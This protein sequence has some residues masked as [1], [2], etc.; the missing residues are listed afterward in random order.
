MKKIISILFILCTSVLLLITGC[1]KNHQG[2][3]ESFGNETSSILY[4]VGKN[5]LPYKDEQIFE[6]LFDRNNLIQVS[7]NISE[8]ELL[9]IQK[10]Y[11]EYSNRGSKS[12][13]YRNASMDITITTE[14]NSITYRIP[15]VGV[16]MKGNTSRTDFYSQEEGQYNL[17]HYRVKFM[18]GEFA[19]LD[20]LELKWN[21]NDDS[22]YIREG[23]AYEM[24]RDMGVL[25]PHTNLV[26]MD[27]SG[28]H[29]GVFTM[30]EPVDKN[31][32]EKNVAEK[33]WGG[34]LYKC[35]WT[36]IGAS[37]TRECSI[38][39][40]DEEHSK[41]YN[42][43]LKTNKLESNHAQMR[44]LIKVLN[45]S[46]VSRESMEEV[47]DMDNFVMFAAVSYFVGNPDDCRNNYNNYYIYFL[48]SSGKAIFIPYDLD[49][50]FGVTKDFNPCG[51]AM[52]ANSPYSTKAKGA[53][54][55]MQKNPLFVNTVQTNSYFFREYTQALK[56]AGESK[57]MTFDHFN[58][59]YCTAEAI[60]GKYTTPEK[61][62]W[63][64]EHHNFHFDVNQSEGLNTNYG[65]ASF[66]EYIDAKMA[67]YDSFVE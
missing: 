6:Q 55:E 23:Y 40:E 42:Y 17:I 35:G 13:I 12:P 61:T 54:N 63:N 19:S 16:R 60:Y 50:V 43:D 20:H 36:H 1:D 4:T 7:L 32:I 11:E 33:D 45:T 28:L 57:W 51:E 52:T 22:T 65:N 39:V 10:D 64:G 56:T 38:G 9:N 8:E 30:Y 24:F 25:A 41:F 15:N 59:Y 21:K 62:F 14:K 26:S 31:F 67:A 46:N 66:R 37:L 5:K 48:K 18:D 34:D 44:N 47:V 49:R 3:N 58:T 53:N 27:V 2:E 29:Q